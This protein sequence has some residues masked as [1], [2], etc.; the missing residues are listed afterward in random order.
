MITIDFMFLSS[1]AFFAKLGST[2][3]SFRP[4]SHVVAMAAHGTNRGFL[5]DVFT[6]YISGK[7]LQFANW[8]LWPSRNRGFSHFHSIMAIEIVDFPMY[9][10]VI[11]Q[12]ANC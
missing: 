11:G 1:A 10:M 9:S 4:S 3:W 5:T 7:R 12:F 6:G 2:T 8:K